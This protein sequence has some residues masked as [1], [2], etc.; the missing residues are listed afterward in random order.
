[1][2]D[3]LTR[4]LERS[5]GIPAQIE[6]L[7]APVHA[8]AGLMLSETAEMAPD[9]AAA[10]PARPA[11]A[12]GRANVEPAFSP[13]ER[14]VPQFAPLAIPESNL[15]QPEAK[16][17]QPSP[18]S[19]EPQFAVPARETERVILTN[20]V[21]LAQPRSS[22]S[23]PPI[24]DPISEPLSAPLSVRAPTTDFGKKMQIVVQPEIVSRLK[25]AASSVI[26]LSRSSPKEPPAIQV[27]IGRVEVRAVVARAA[28]RPPSPSTSK[29]SLEEYLKNRNGSL[30]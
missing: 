29:V 14:E 20:A 26:P 2:S 30:A 24:A 22:V 10:P 9:P 12:A 5:L 8:P 23:P 28:S 21:P 15:A 25:P 3:Y 11:G 27:T 7:I 17:A 4:L 6:P 13:T 16:S 1:M 18:P 19:R